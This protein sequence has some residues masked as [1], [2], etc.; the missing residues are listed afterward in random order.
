[1]I[2]SIIER[3]SIKD[4]LEYYGIQP[5]KGRNNYICPFHNDKH[6]SAGITKDGNKFHCFSC[7]WTGNI[8][9][10]VMEFEKLGKKEAMK[11]IDE[12]FRLG[13][14]KQLSRKEK[15]ELARAIK[16]SERAKLEQERKEREQN[17]LL[18]DIINELRFWEDIQKTCHITRGEYKRGEWELDDL[19]FYSLKMQ[20]KLNWQIDNLLGIV[21]P[22]CEFDFYKDIKGEK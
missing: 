9:D 6:P 10:I 12:K 22:Y 17:L 18:A 3:V 16:K 1:M 2:E 19:F 5:Q 15:L 13:L 4:I 14:Y 11:F 21:H 8:I 7:G 20:D